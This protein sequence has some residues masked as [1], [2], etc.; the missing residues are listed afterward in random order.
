MGLVNGL[1]AEVRMKPN[2]RIRM[3][4]GMVA[5]RGTGSGGE[6]ASALVLLAPLAVGRDGVAGV[7][8]GEGRRT[9]RGH[10]QGGL[11]R[12][13]TDPRRGGLPRSVRRRCLCMLLFRGC[14]KGGRGGTYVRPTVECGEIKC[15]SA[16]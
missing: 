6:P 14:E 9:R 8:R 2:R 5:A 12:H 11:W 3:A 4:V 15:C 10:R 13:G 16:T 1:C 7:G